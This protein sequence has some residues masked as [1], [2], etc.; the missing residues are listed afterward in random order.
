MAAFR[1][2]F[3]T[4]SATRLS[5]HCDGALGLGSQQDI[6]H[7]F[8]PSIDPG[9][10]LDGLIQAQIIPRLM[11]VHRQPERIALP[12]ANEDCEIHEEDVSRL[13][14][15]LLGPDADAGWHCVDAIRSR[16]VSVETVLLELLTPVARRL[17]EMW[18][19]DTA[20]FVDVTIG[21]SRLQSMLK[22]LSP[23]FIR[24]IGDPAKVARH[25]DDHVRRILL[26]PSP[27]DQHSFGLLIVEDFFRNAGW[28]V[29]S[30]FPNDAGAVRRALKAHY[31]SAI[32]YSLSSQNFLD[33]LKLSIQWARKVSKNRDVK[34]LVGGQVFVSQP[35]LSESVG[36]DIFAVDARDA[37]KQAEAHLAESGGRAVPG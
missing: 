5:Q 16:G 26:L 7:A 28:E 31:F 32:G 3:E 30:G 2:P 22:R 27:G 19:A 33:P 24:R 10:E 25:N 29:W 14:H 12:S 35:G 34:V 1:P 9:A 13:T 18:E 8:A 6:G 23:P 20:D 11:F 36:A 15:H 17:G 37:V 4:T 21:L